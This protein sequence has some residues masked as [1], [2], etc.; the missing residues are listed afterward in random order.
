MSFLRTFTQTLSGRVKAP[1][2]GLLNRFLRSDNTFQEVT[3]VAEWGSVTGDIADQTDLIALLSAIPTLKETEIDFGVLP[4]IT[5]GVFNVIDTDITEDSIIIAQKA[6][7]T[8]SDLREIDEII[9]ES[10]D[11]SAKANDGSL[12]IYVN[13]IG[14]VTGKFIIN[15]IH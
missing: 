6:I 9:V 3:G 5:S 13:S 4:F 1:G 10:L 8:T 15:Y 7:K 11:V 2:A 14:S 12:D